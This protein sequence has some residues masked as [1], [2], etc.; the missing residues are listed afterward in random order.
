MKS[1]DT[2]KYTNPNNEK[3]TSNPK[4][5]APA[6]E[7]LLLE[8]KDGEE[9]GKIL[10]TPA[11]AIEVERAVLQVGQKLKLDEAKRREKNDQ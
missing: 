11:I 10:E 1:S 3:N 6:E 9:L 7:R 4:D 2:T 5:E 8:M